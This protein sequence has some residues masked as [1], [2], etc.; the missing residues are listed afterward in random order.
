MEGTTHCE[1]LK[2]WGGRGGSDEC[3]RLTD[4]MS[5]EGC[6]CLSGYTS[7]VSVYGRGGGGKTRVLS[8][9]IC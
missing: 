8:V 4:C 1:L 5:L 6:V 7:C 2:E 3:T 9:F